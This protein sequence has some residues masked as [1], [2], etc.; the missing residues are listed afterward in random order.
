VLVL[1][2]A[3]SDLLLAETAAE[4]TRRGPGAQ[5]VEIPGVGHAP[6]LTTPDQ[7]AIVRD[8]LASE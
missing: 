1:R 6:S 4:M 5:L 3:D 7:I 2:G 8:W